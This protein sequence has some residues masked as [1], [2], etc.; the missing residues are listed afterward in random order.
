MIE[1]RRETANLIRSLP[2]KHQELD[3]QQA[4]PEFAV[5]VGVLDLAAKRLQGLLRLTS[6]AGG[7]FLGF[8]LRPELDRP[9]ILVAAD[10]MF[11]FH[12]NCFA[13]LTKKLK[14]KQHGLT[15]RRT[16]LNHESISAIAN[17]VCTVG[18]GCAIAGRIFGVARVGVAAKLIEA[19]K[20]DGAANVV[21][22]AKAVLAETL[23]GT[24]KVDE[25]ANF[26]SAV[27]VAGVA[28]VDDGAARAAGVA[29]VA[30]VATAD[31]A[32][33]ADEAAT[34]TRFK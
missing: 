3:L 31:G 27:T 5:R 14:K 21:G 24:A 11:R 10:F 4:V 17:F 1:K 34:R 16:C 12:D 33:G 32:A 9:K 29:T 25:V 28:T 6:L 8:P 22:V 26:A 13:K 2:Q 20:V 19:A 23:V 7:C 30:G 15:N 18:D